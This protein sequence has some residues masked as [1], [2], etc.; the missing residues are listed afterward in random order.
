MDVQVNCLGCL[1]LLALGPLAVGA[2]VY[3]ALRARGRRATW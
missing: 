2:G 1:V 3:G